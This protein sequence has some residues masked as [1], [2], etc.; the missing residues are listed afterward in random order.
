MRRS[1]LLVSLL[2]CSLVP[3]LAGCVSQGNPPRYFL[4]QSKA[5]AGDHSGGLSV[6]VHPITVPEYLQR[7]ALLID[8]DASRLR[9]SFDGRWGEPVA[10][11]IHRVSTVELSRLLDTGNLQRWPWSRQQRP[12]IEVKIAVLAMERHDSTA[13]LSAEVAVIDNRGAESATHRFVRSWRA[14]VPEASDDAIAEAY[15]TLVQAMNADIAA[16]VNAG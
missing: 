14:P 16:A 10:D 12:E 8:S 15:S 4:L 9:Y 6:G 11:G 3:L 1:L 7:S 5:P 2:L 13:L